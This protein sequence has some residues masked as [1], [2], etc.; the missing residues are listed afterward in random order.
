MTVDRDENQMDYYGGKSSKRRTCCMISWL[1]SALLFACL[2]FFFIE[3]DLLEIANTE[4]IQ[5]R[6]GFPAFEKWKNPPAPIIVKVYL[7]GVTNSEAFLNG[8]DKKLVLEEVGPIVY[9]K[10][11]V[12][13]DIVF[14]KNSTLSFTT[15]YDIKFPEKENIPG[16]LNRTLIVPNPMTLGIAAMIHDKIGN[17]FWGVHKQVYTWVV[18][19]RDPVFLNRTVHEILWHMTTK[20]LEDI[21]T[22]LK[23]M[24]AVFPSISLTVPR[25]NAGLLFNVS[26]FYYLSESSF[27]NSFFSFSHSTQFHTGT[28]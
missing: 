12:Q 21:K 7:F 6:P 13:K 25:P 23:N 24:K 10:Y 16:I 8:T 27:S 26:V 14:E 5:V 2:S 11:I 22:T 4:R 28:T 3:Y 20:S 18:N 15:E 19:S 17:D 9:H 1:L